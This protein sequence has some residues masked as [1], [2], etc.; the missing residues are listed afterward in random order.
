MANVEPSDL[1]ASLGESEID[2][3]LVRING[4][5]HPGIT[6]ALMGL[7]A[8]SGAGV[9][10]VEQII[11]RGRLVLNLIVA[12]PSGR[13]L[14]KELL[15][16]GWERKIEIDF[17]VV[18]PNP[19]PK[20]PGLVVT[21]L[22]H[23][24]TPNEFGALASSIAKSGGNIDRIVRLASDPVLAYELVVSGDD[25]EGIRASLLQTADTLRADVAVHREGLGRRATRLVVLDVDSTLIREEVIEL[26]ADEAGCRDQVAEITERAMRGEI[27]FEESLHERVALFEGLPVGLLDRV[28]DR[29]ELT[30]GARTFIRTLKRLGYRTAIVSGGFTLATEA[31]AEQLGIDHA[32]ANTLEV[33]EGLLTGR[34]TGLIV[35]RKGKAELVRKIAELEEIP[36]DQVVAIGDGANDLDML[37]AAGLGIAF[38]AKPVVQEA[39]DTTLNVPYLDAILFVLGVRRTDIEEADATPYAPPAP[40]GLPRQ[41]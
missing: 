25:R 27:D 19:T 12:V 22:G 17:E 5:D 20:T 21:I 26:V 14:V 23:E 1:Q 37:N 13:D 6:A 38:N 30:P 39:A 2:T 15:H 36:L 32:Y 34:V 8:D 29:I 24:V 31:L 3:I 18:D 11:I 4:P 40:G 10:D 9:E 35:D 16:F 41:G 28:I 33:H 7:L